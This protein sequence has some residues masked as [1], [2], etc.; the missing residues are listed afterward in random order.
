MSEIA[1]DAAILIDPE[2]TTAAAAIIV[3]RI[4]EARSLRQAGLV[5]VLRF[6]AEDVIDRYCEIYS[7]VLSHSPQRV[8]RENV[9]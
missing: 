5:N 4:G 3:A 6:S 1:G 9:S 8:S 7:E 2:D